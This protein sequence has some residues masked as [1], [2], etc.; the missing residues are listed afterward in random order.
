MRP[1]LAR[2]PKVEWR[3]DEAGEAICG[4]RRARACAHVAAL[5]AA[6]RGAARAAH[7]AVDRA[8]ARPAR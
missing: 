8:E 1:A 5:P 4:R 7:A 3:P 6:S 2:T